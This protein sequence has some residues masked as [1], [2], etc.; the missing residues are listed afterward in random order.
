MHAVVVTVS[1]NDFDQASGI[2]R[3]E[4]VPQVKRAPGLIAGYWVAID[5][6]QKGRSVIVFESEEQA[7]NAAN[8]VDAAQNQGVTFESIDVGEVVASA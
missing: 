1:I 8:M 3:D 6:H 2:L 7:Q 4:I 5:G